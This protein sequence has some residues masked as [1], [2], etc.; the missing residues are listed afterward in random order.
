MTPRRAF[1]LEKLIV[2]HVVKKFHAFC[3]T[4]GFIRARHWPLT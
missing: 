1:L 2:V 3:G 4:G